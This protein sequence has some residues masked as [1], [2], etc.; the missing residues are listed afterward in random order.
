MNKQTYKLVN[1]VDKLLSIGQ[2]LIYY[3]NS[4]GGDT[5]HEMISKFTF[6]T[7][8]TGELLSRLYEKDNHYHKSL[9]QFRATLKLTNLHS[10][11]VYL[12]SEIMGVLQAVK[13]DLE[14]GLLDDI[15]KLLQADINTSKK[16]RRGTNCFKYLN[17]EKVKTN[18]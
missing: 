2:E 6:W 4:N 5:S 18:V 10:G 11:S 7:T 13:Y 14:N 17:F 12:L 9:N 15:K 1:E 16:R 3:G 8:R